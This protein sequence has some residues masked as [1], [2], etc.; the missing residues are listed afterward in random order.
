MVKIDNM[1]TLNTTIQM[2]LMLD[3][4]LPLIVQE[5]IELEYDIRAMVLHDKVIGVMK[6]N[7]IKG[8]DFK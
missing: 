2:I 6:R 3:K 7:V 8:S 4:K 1:R 5:F